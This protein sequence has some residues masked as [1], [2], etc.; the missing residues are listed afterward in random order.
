MSLK[1][2]TMVA[3]AIALA[4]SLG[5]CSSLT[6][7]QQA[8]LDTDLA[9]VKQLAIA[10][11]KPYAEKYIAAQVANGSMTADEAAALEKALGQLQV[12]APKYKVVEKK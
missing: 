9:V 10:I 3:V 6:A 1:K 7:A 5:A 2:I 12:A 11:G 4:L 8:Q